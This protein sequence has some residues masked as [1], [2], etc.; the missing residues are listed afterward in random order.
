MLNAFVIQRFI[1]EESSKQFNGAKIARKVILISYDGHLSK[2]SWKLWT[3][4]RF[5]IVR[6]S[7]VSSE[8]TVPLARS[9]V[10]NIRLSLAEY[11]NISLPNQII[12]TLRPDETPRNQ[13]HRWNQYLSSHRFSS[14]NASKAA[15][16]SDTPFLERTLTWQF[17]YRFYLCSRLHRFYICEHCN[18]GSTLILELRNRCCAT[19]RDTGT[20]VWPKIKWKLDLN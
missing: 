3:K 12:W 5:K 17:D 4:T 2:L 19:F 9:R 10:E 14:K 7:R 1:V 15:S 18:A 6:R 20:R 16:D 13:L 11:L 8:N